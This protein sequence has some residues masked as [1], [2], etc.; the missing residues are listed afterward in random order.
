[1][2]LTRVEALM[3]RRQVHAEIKADPEKIVFY[4]QEE[5][6]DG[7]GGS[8]LTPLAP[9]FTAEVSII[10]AKRRL[11]TMLVGTELGDVV[12]Y[13]Y[14]VLARAGVDIRRGDQFWW[15]GD[16]FTV[17]SIHIKTQVSVTAQVDYFGGA[18]NG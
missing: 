3:A 4:R 1:M 9:A 10:P 17:Q 15:K 6:P 13:S 16:H 2:A 5:V 11:S 14:I 8:T 7:V 18:R 12:N